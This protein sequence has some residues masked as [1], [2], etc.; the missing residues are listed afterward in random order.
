LQS[1]CIKAKKKH[2]VDVE[3]LMRSGGSGGEVLIEHPL[4][5]N[6]ALQLQSFTDI[7]EATLEDLYP[8]HICDYV[9]ILS[10]A[11]AE[12]VTQCRVLGSP[13]MKTDCCCVISWP[14]PCN[15]ALICWELVMSRE[16]KTIIYFS[17]YE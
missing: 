4:E 1:I 17:K 2:N 16:S 3:E 12:F 13:E 5:R 10:I 11:S 8:Y 9:Y 7:I 6:L 15:N 14:R